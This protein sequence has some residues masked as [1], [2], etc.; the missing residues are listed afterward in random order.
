[1]DLVRLF[2]D[3]DDFV[4]A[5]HSNKNYQL[6]Y[7]KSR[8]GIP[9]Q[10]SLSEMMTIIIL[11]HSSG[12]KNFKSFY[13]YVRSSMRSEFPSILSYTRFIDWMPYCLIPLTHFSQTKM[14]K[15]TGISF[16]D[17]TSLRVC[18]NIRIP[19]NKV[20]KG[21]ASRGKSSMGWFFGFKLHIVVNEKGDLLNFMITN[22]NTHDIVPVEKLCHELTGKLFG[23]KG[24]CSQKL[25]KLLMGRGLQLVTNLRGNMKNKLLPL[26][27]K[28]LL[29]KRFII[30][31]INDQLKNICDIEHS[32]HRSPTNFL[33]NIIAGLISYSYRD[34]KP[35]I[36]WG[37]GPLIL[38]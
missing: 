16:I 12:F 27:D 7:A 8:R 36:K 11:Y 1:M 25:S 10:V 20:F 22:G 6:T 18:K 24:Y 19:R 32:R 3:V 21:I 4:K 23:D 33:V 17:S 15:N 31:T 9:A 26:M 37:N 35:S 30:E 34:G 14:G 28:I 29:R 38:N 5:L 2:C 13:F